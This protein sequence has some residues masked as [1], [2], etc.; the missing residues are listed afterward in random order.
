MTTN[1]RY[2]GASSSS[3]SSFSATSASNPPTP[4][5]DLDTDDSES[6]EYAN[7]PS[8]YFDCY[9]LGGRAVPENV[10]GARES[11]DATAHKSSLLLH[12]L[13]CTINDGK[14]YRSPT[15]HPRRVMDIGSGTCTWSIHFAM[16]NQG[17]HAAAVD[18]S[19]FMPQH[20]L[21]NIEKIREDLNLALPSED[22]TADLIFFG[23][24]CGARIL[25]GYSATH[26]DFSNQEDG[27]SS[28]G[29]NLS[30]DTNI[31][32][33]WCGSAWGAMWDGAQIGCFP[34]L[35]SSSCGLTTADLYDFE[36]RDQIM[37]PL[38]E[39][40]GFTLPEIELLAMGM[41]EELA[42]DMEFESFSVYAQKPPQMTVVVTF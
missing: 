12:L 40:L 19:P 29:L 20:V 36:I 3:S 5:S 30:L 1:K 37:L 33:G 28:P 4:P 16:Q 7:V 11:V 39:G 35:T 34:L 23:S 18:K 42:E 13:W 32:S 6:S 25:G 2:D 41:R 21:P 26:A 9:L 15:S 24:L 38:Y 27:S 31:R 22:S 10:E 8:E 17:S 14:F